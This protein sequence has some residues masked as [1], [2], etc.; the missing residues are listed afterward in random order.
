MSANERVIKD[1]I[2]DLT[3]MEGVI[4]ARA[5]MGSYIVFGNKEHKAKTMCPTQVIVI[6][7]SSE[8]AGN[9]FEEVQSIIKG[10]VSSV[11]GLYV[12]FTISYPEEKSNIVVPQSNLVDLSTFKNRK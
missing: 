1:T 10:H 11:E 6:A 9:I 3:K 7:G 12:D 8:I 2:N 4:E 5:V